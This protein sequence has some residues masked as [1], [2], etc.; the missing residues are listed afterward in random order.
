MYLVKL[1]NGRI[2]RSQ[3]TLS[4][5]LI[6]EFSIKNLFQRRLVLREGSKFVFYLYRLS[7]GEENLYFA[8]RQ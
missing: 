5:R 1:C 4:T 6:Q 2:D 3:T 7:I 8:A